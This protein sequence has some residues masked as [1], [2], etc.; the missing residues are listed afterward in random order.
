MVIA[1]GILAISLLAGVY[2]M[3][4]DSA[5]GRRVIWSVGMEAVKERPL[6]GS[7]FGRFAAVYGDAQVAYFV[8][9]DRNDA[10]STGNQK[11]KYA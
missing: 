10:E 8:K 4:K 7:G 3:K 9:L 2:L 5:D 11:L 1:G 6:F